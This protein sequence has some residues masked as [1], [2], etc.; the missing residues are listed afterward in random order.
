MRKAGNGFANTGALSPAFLCSPEHLLLGHFV[1]WLACALCGNVACSIM[2]HRAT[3][4]QTEKSHEAGG[5]AAASAAGKRRLIPLPLIALTPPALFGIAVGGMTV[6]L[7]LADPALHRLGLWL[8][9]VPTAVVSVL[10]IAAGIIEARLAMQNRPD[11]EPPAEPKEE[12]QKR[13]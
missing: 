7:K 2:N 4:R 1:D 13:E 12:A 11:D 10:A 8:I 9:W 5:K 6:L 3:H